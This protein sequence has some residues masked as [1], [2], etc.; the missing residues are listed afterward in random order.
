MTDFGKKSSSF[1]I[2]ADGFN[3]D[4]ERPSGQAMTMNRLYYHSFGENCDR[5]LSLSKFTDKVLH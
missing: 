5:S 2:F 4:R 3:L 1:P